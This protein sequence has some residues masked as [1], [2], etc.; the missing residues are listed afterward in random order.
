MRD[1]KKYHSPYAT[2]Q[3]FSWWSRPGE[4]DHGVTG[5]RWQA[6]VEAVIEY[7]E[8]RLRIQSEIEMD[9]YEQVLRWILN[10]ITYTYFRAFA[11]LETELIW[12]YAETGYDA[13][14]PISW[15]TWTLRDVIHMK[16]KIN[17]QYWIL[18]DFRWEDM[19]ERKHFDSEMSSVLR[20]VYVE[21]CDKQCAKDSVE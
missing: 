2:E 9:W 16:V 13:W 18:V 15:W 12:Y 20:K 17:I 21:V 5:N 10:D 11:A 19:W 4:Y 3:G 6:R 14:L 7:E 8:N 1:T